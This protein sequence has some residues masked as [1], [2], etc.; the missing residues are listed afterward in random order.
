[1]LGIWLNQI[2]QG[3]LVGG[4]YALFA[5]GLSLSVG[6]M[7]FVNIAHGDLIVL[8]SFILWSLTQALGLPTL[9]AIAII[10]PLTFAGGYLLQ[11]LL[12]Q[13]VLGKDVLSIILVTFGL[14]IIVQNGLQG[15]YGADI[16]KVSGG[17]I[18]TATLHLGNN[19]NIGVLPLIIFLSAI[20]MIWGLDLLLYR[21]RIGA[22]IRAVSDSV[23]TAN[24]VGLPSARIYA[25]A[26]GVVGVTMAISAGFMA[27]WTNFDPTSGPSR[28]LIAFEAVVLGGLGSLWGTLVGGIVIGIAQAVGAQFDAAWQVLAGHIVFLV[29]F[30]A[31]PQGLFPKY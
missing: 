12:L 6:V 9:V 10:L 1:M 30:L 27:V 3:I 25:I 20:A 18:E 4:L 28:L 23:A 16:R 22:R 29:I 21:S 19:I 15:V 26:M 11:R 24:L 17:A 31:R 8:I 13:R 5:M 14:S 7:R 2:V